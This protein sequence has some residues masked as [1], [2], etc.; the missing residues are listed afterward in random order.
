MESGTPGIKGTRDGWL[1]RVLQFS[2]EKDDSPF[3]AV[4]MTQQLPRS[5]YGRAPSVAM[6]NLADFAIKAGI[7]TQ[8]MKGGFE[9]VYAAERPRT[10]S[11]KW[12]RKPSRRSIF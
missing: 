3:R 11:A 12:A 4:A 5:L 6:T 8:D 9:G 10:A 7:Y 2:A 1:N